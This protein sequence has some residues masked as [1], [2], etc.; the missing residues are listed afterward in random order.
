VAGESGHWIH[1]DRPE[2]V[3]QVKTTCCSFANAMI[4][5]RTE[6]LVGTGT[7]GTLSRQVVMDENPSHHVFVN[8]NVE[9]HV[10]EGY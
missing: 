10:V 2:L 3:A 4:S 8:L 5:T 7:A 1:L 6:F 9:H